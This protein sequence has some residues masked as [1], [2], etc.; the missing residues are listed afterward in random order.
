MEWLD[1]TGLWIMAIILLPNL[2]F[3]MKRQP[4]FS[5]E[6]PNKILAL[7]EQIGRYGCMIFLV[8]NIPCTQTGFWFPYASIVYPLGNAALLTAY[9]VCW[10]VFW[11]KITATG[12]F[13][14]SALPTAIFL[15]SGVVRGSIPLLLSAVIFGV[16]HISI[17]VGSRKNPIES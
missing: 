3:A 16:C 12:A 7:F 9:F 15:F 14:L 8:L 13:L 11:N 17:S 5:P 2:L 1:L 10:V 4:A 6:L